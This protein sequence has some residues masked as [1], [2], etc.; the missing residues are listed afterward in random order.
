VFKTKDGTVQ[1]IFF[2]KLL[3]SIILVKTMILN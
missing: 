3:E 1:L 2:F